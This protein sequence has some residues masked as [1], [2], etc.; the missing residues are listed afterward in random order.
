MTVMIQQFCRYA[1]Q[2]IKNIII[3]IKQITN[4]NLGS[5]ELK[6][7]WTKIENK[8]ITTSGWDGRNEGNNIGSLIKNYAFL[9]AFVEGDNNWSNKLLFI[10]GC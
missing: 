10:L 3:Q 7:N 4:Q 8:L 6:K 1:N 9:A 2:I 5:F